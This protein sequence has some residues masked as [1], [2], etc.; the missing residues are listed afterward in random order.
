MHDFPPME[1]IELEIQTEEN[2]ACHQSIMKFTC[3]F[4][5]CSLYVTF[6]LFSQNISSGPGHLFKENPVLILFRACIMK[7]LDRIQYIYS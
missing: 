3:I 6:S 5:L 2:Q 7:C 4:F 1:E